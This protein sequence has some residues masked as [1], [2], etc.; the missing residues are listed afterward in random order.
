MSFR[1]DNENSRIHSNINCS[2]TDN[3]LFTVSCT[4]I[5]PSNMVSVK[6]S[7]N[8]KKSKTIKICDDRKG[9]E[10]DKNKIKTPQSTSSRLKRGLTVCFLY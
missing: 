9:N 6:N 10:N 3:T 7:S 2:N 8:K 5:R 1:D 4:K